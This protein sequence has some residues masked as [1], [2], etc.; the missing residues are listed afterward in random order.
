[1]YSIGQS[2]NVVEVMSN[3]AESTKIPLQWC[4]MR[5]KFGIAML[6]L[7]DHASSACFGENNFISN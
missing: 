6:A 3:L 1:M 2:F 7:S 4:A 5:I